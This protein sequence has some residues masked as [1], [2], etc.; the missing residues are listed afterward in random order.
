MNEFKIVS[1][2]NTDN[3]MNYRFLKI[4]L[5][6]MIFL[7]SLSSKSQVSNDQLLDAFISDN[8]LCPYVFHKHC[9]CCDTIYIVDTSNF[10]TEK[11]YVKSYKKPKISRHLKKFFSTISV[12]ETYSKT[13]IVSKE[14]LVPLLYPF[15]SFPVKSDTTGINKWQCKCLHILCISKNNNKYRIEFVYMGISNIYGYI[16]YKHKRKKIIKVDSVFGEF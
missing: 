6:G 3:D 12:P 8:E 15:K 13:I 11:V 9:K 5:A 1:V 10:F 4:I 7:I 14:F 2:N 16:E